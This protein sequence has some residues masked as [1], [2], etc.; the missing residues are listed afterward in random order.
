MQFKNVNQTLRFNS[1][2]TDLTVQ[3]LTG[4]LNV[5]RDSLDAT[6]VEG[7]FEISTKHKDISLGD[8]KH[9]VKIS[10]TNGDVRLET[11]VP[12]AQAIE[13]DVNKGGI[14]LTLPA[15]SSFQ[16]EASSRHGEVEC[17]FPGLTVNK[18]AQT[19]TITGTFGKGG[20]TVRLSA[21]YGT[22]RL[23]RQGLRLPA[24]PEP[25]TPPKVPA[26]AASDE[27]DEQIA[28]AQPPALCRPV[29][30]SARREPAAVW[31]HRVVSIL[32][33][34]NTCL[35]INVSQPALDWMRGAR[36]RIGRT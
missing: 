10:T 12:P 35:L 34:V 20:P 1:S 24:P 13:V 23:M 26:S 32:R 18:E 33:S 31:P 11:S 29:A 22:V 7:P 15:K 14:D 6:G 30:A 4:R 5:E 21:S 9:S 3:K 16:I 25:P 17:D 36:R 8:F 27:A 19:P 28:W 2:R